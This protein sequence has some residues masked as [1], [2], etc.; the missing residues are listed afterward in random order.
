MLVALS[1]GI[2]VSVIYNIKQ[3]K[4]LNVLEEGFALQKEELEEEYSQ[5]ALQYEGYGM[6]IENDSLFSLYENEKMKVQN[7]LEELKA[8]KATNATR[9][10]QLRRE[11]E[12][13]KKIMRSYIAQ[14][15][16][17]NTVNQQLKNEN[18]EVNR[19]YMEVTSTVTKLNAEKKAL[20]ETVRIASQMN[21]SQIVVNLLDKKMKVTTKSKKAVKIQTSFILSQNKTTK[22]G[23]KWVYTRI[24]KP[25]N[26]V[27]VKS[28]GNVFR[29]ENKN[30]P[31]SSKREIEYD[32]EE[33]SVSI[34]WDIE[35]YLPVGDYIV[36]IFVDGAM[37]GEKAFSIKK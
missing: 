11:L 6:K 8:V 36:D 12:T 3:K 13:V 9:I 37:I 29:Y 17:L 15:D 32:G 30:I 5:I 27:L 23:K 31:Y 1:V 21:A 10:S 14:I 19:R 34:Y 16:S 7:L 18:E 4:E 2:I 35:E 20:S 28:E 33:Q 22:V 24:Y 26:S 25:D